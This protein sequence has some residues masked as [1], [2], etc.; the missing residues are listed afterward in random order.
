MYGLFN[1]LILYVRWTRVSTAPPKE[2]IRSFVDGPS[3]PGSAL[4]VYENRFCPQFAFVD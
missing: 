4:D 3:G 1:E 2:D